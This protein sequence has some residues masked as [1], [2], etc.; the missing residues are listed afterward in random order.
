M[1]SCIRN[2]TYDDASLKQ[3]HDFI[4][5]QQKQSEIEK[6]DA[7]KEYKALLKEW[8]LTQIEFKKSSKKV[9]N[10]DILLRD[11]NKYWSKIFL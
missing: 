3:L 5:S 4:Y 1:G 11:P 9:E 6:N 2:L 7:E 8:Q 10:V